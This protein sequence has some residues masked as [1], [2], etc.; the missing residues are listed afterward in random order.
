MFRDS[1]NDLLLHNKPPKSCGFKNLYYYL[2]G[3]VGGLS[4][5]D[6]SCSESHLI[7]GGGCQVAV[8]AGVNW[9]LCAHM[10]SVW[11]GWGCWT[12]PV[13]SLSTQLLRLASLGFLTAWWQA[14]PRASIPREPSKASHAL[15]LEIPECQFYHIKS[16][17][18]FWLLLYSILRKKKT[19]CFPIT[20]FFSI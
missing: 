13:M 16:K 1:S 12:W 3:S 2:Y 7:L 4:S 6:G 5:A 14:F 8:G 9:R 11:N 10:Y 19:N 15:A 18:F 20:Y 17:G